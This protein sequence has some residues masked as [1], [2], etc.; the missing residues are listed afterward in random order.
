VKFYTASKNR[1]DTPKLIILFGPTGVGKTELLERLFSFHA[2]VISADA[3]QVYMDLDIGTAK[4]GAE[5]LSKIPHHLI[6]ILDY[7]EK[8]SAGEFRD[9]ADNLIPR[10]IDNGRLPVISGGTAF[11]I[12]AWLMGLPET[13]P[14]DPVIRAR[15][16]ELWKNKGD[17]EIRSALETVDPV[18]ARRIGRRDRYRMLRALEVHA[19]TGGRLS[20]IAVPDTVRQDYQVLLLGLYRDRKQLYD[21]IN[22]R[23]RGMMEAGLEGEVAALRAGGAERDHPGMKAIGY[24][25][26]FSGSD[27]QTIEALIARNTRRYAK[28]QITFFNSLP[29]VRWF[30]AADDPETSGLCRTVNDFLAV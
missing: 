19:Q 22:L 23:V 11:Y 26:W 6:S 3:L 28:R 25:E 16:E 2:E 4:P 1:T 24:R 29:D 27:R 20:E 9:R 10:I 15:I 30:D 8:F 7:R 17:D 18:S 14:V 21:R 5:F 12:R 13:P